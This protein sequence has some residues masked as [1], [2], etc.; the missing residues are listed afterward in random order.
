[1]N[2]LWRV[3]SC[4][5]FL[6]FNILEAGA[7][8]ISFFGV[9][10][11]ILL[12]VPSWWENKPVGDL[13]NDLIKLVFITK[14]FLLVCEVC[15]KFWRNLIGTFLNLLFFSTILFM[16]CLRSTLFYI[17]NYDFSLFFSKQERASFDSIDLLEWLDLFDSKSV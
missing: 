10:N 9:E 14:S 8:S 5:R 3:L 1:M 7:S 12:F 15:L 2:W 6:I 17:G 4:L 16:S 11:P 13:C